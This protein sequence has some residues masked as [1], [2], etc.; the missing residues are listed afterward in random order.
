MPRKIPEETRKLIEDLGNK[1][2]SIRKIAEKAGV[3]NSFAWFLVNLRK[4]GYSTYTEYLQHLAQNKGLENLQEYEKNLAKRRGHEDYSEYLEKL[5]SARQ[6][7]KE[8]RELSDLIKKTLKKLNKN[9]A[10]LASQ[11]EVSHQMVSRYNSGKSYPSQEVLQRIYQ[12]LNVNYKTID[13]K[14]D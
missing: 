7:K 13:S 1:G 2:V 10:W 4:K 6:R 8:N 5:A 3:S 12:V 9:Q 11:L 14:L